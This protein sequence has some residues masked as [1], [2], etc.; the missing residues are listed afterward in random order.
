MTTSNLL[1]TAKA[2]SRVTTSSKLITDKEVSA[3]MFGGSVT[4]TILAKWR[5]RGRRKAIGLPFIKIGGRVM[6]RVDDCER[7]IESRRVVPGE[8]K[9]KKHARGK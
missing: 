4:V 2:E 6:Y 5:S 8:S 9:P 3:E 7:F 1:A